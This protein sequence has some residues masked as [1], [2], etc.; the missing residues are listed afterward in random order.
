MKTERLTLSKN[1]LKKRALREVKCEDER[2]NKVFENFLADLE[3][4]FNGNKKDRNIICRDA[5]MELYLGESSNYEDIIS[6]QKTP[7]SKKTLVASFDPRNITL[8]PEYYQDIDI[9]KFSKVKPLIWLWTMFDRSP[10][11]RNCYLGFPFRRL[12]AKRIFKKCGENLKIFHDV[13][14]SYGYN[15]SVGDNVVIH[16]NVLLDDR[17]ELIIED[18]ASISD[19]VN[20]YSH[21][22]SIFDQGDVTIGKTVIGNN[23]R[24]TYHSTILAGV[25]VGQEAMVGA[26]GLATRD[27]RN[28]H[29][30]VG[31]PAKSGRV[32]PNACVDECKDE[33]CVHKG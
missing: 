30:N 28:V 9:E 2:I 3:A 8:E 15:I 17:G 16:R 4:K 14:F 19:Y 33:T 20:I 21:S 27:G 1:E 22:H 26:L 24:L 10:V 18:N 23:S 5:L 12:L 7:L 31:T 13:E 29:I 32:K 6:D 11:G 25:K